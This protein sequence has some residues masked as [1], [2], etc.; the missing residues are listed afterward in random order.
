M[1]HT[2]IIKN[3]T[4]RDIFATLLELITYYNLSYPVGCHEDCQVQLNDIKSQII[5]KDTI[6]QMDDSTYVKLYLL[7]NKVISTIYKEVYDELLI[8][9]NN[10]RNCRLF[11]K[12]GI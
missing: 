2:K 12:E 4:N 10:D 9:K 8:Q 7:S 5:T 3:L 11:D 6:Y 1:Q